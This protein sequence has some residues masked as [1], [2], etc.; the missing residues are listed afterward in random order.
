[1]KNGYKMDISGLTFFAFIIIILFK[2][3]FGL[4][5]YIVQEGYYDD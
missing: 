2:I 4:Y 3:L 1:M 5:A